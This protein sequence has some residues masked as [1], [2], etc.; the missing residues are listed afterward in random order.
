MAKL[1]EVVAKTLHLPEPL[2][3]KGVAPP[4]KSQKP[5]EPVFQNQWIPVQDSQQHHDE[6]LVTLGNIEKSFYEVN[7]LQAQLPLLSLPLGDELRIPAARWNSRT[8]T[9]LLLTG[10]KPRQL[11]TEKDKKLFLFLM[12]GNV[13]LCDNLIELPRWCVGSSLYSGFLNVTLLDLIPLVLDIAAIRALIRYTALF[14][15]RG[16]VEATL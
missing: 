11:M 6:D 14:P 3:W 9:T 8:S 4:A 10:L 5:S 12:I 13:L 7:G 16:T 1:A 15:S 2:G